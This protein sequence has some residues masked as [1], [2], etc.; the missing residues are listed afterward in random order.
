MRFHVNHRR[1]G[2]FAFS[3]WLCVALH[4]AVFSASGW[5]FHG[6]H[7]HARGFEPCGS[8]A[9]AGMDGSG[10]SSGGSCERRERPCACYRGEGEP[11]TSGDGHEPG[12]QPE[13]PRDGR[14]PGGCSICM[15]ISAMRHAAPAEPIALAVVRVDVRPE[16]PLWAQAVAVSILRRQ[17]SRGPP[18][19]GF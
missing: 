2:F 17:W 19:S 10:C 15:A 4:L 11:A 18:M 1:T 14:D 13:Q 5:H 16:P 9:C 6:P 8:T 7:G 3:V 12:E